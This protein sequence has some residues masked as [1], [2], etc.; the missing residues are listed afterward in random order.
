MC[1]GGSS[2]SADWEPEKLKSSFSLVV[3]GIGDRGVTP[4][5]LNSNFDWREYFYFVRFAR[6]P[7]APPGAHYFVVKISFILLK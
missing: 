6:R 1:R 3:Q 4:G 5:E 7:G 2:D